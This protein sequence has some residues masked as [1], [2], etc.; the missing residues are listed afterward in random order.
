MPLVV[1]EHLTSLLQ[2]DRLQCNIVFI[3]FPIASCVALLACFAC[4]PRLQ[5][6]GMYCYLEMIHVLDFL[7][8]NNAVML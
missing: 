8:L 1:E 2:A 4:L 5:A 7:L 3:W 6:F